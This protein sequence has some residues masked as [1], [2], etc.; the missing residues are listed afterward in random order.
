M[1]DHAQH[2]R[3][4]A[5]DVAGL[6]LAVGVVLEVDGLV[7]VQT[8]RVEVVADPELQAPVLEEKL[9]AAMQVPGAR[10][11]QLRVHLDPMDGVLGEDATRNGQPA[12]P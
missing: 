3:E 12:D 2:G 6:E 9:D 5:G 8:K 4:Q 1:L 7:A 11:L 10:L